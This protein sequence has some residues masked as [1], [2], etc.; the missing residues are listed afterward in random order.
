MVR[1]AGPVACRVEV[2]VDRGE[3]RV[4]VVD[5]GRRGRPMLGH[6]VPAGPP[7]DGHGLLGMR[8]RVAAFDGSFAAGPR[9]DGGF[10]VS[11]TLPY[12]AVSP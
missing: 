9:T 6:P 10:A 2:T 11:A 3:V 1:H 5:E 8:E 7:V 12:R 4:E